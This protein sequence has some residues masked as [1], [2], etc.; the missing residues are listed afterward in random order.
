MDCLHNSP[1]SILN[2]ASLKIFIVFL[3][4]QKINLPIWTHRRRTYTLTLA[5]WPMNTLLLIFWTILKLTFQLHWG[6]ILVWLNRNLDPNLFI[7]PIIDLMFAFA[8]RNPMDSFSFNITPLPLVFLPLTFINWFKAVR[9]SLSFPGWRLI[10][11]FILWL[12]NNL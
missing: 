4:V 12:V 2:S 6:Q 5:H 10:V 3:A 9:H 7:Q 1:F 11:Y 8:I